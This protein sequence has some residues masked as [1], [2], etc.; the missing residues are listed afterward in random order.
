MTDSSPNLKNV[1]LQVHATT[2]PHLD[3]VEKIILDE[4]IKQG[5]AVIINES[6]TVTVN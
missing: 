6:G 1:C 4:L 5:R 3:L 2:L